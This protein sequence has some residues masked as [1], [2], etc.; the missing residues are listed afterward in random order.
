M[1]PWDVVGGARPVVGPPIFAFGTEGR[2]VTVRS[3][4]RRAIHLVDALLREGV[5]GA[6]ATSRSWALAPRG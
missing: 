6:A 1:T 4:Q 2:A 5:I 3:Q